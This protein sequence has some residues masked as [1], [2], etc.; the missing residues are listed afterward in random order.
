V[1]SPALLQPHPISIVASL[2]V[3]V[4]CVSIFPILLNCSNLMAAVSLLAPPRSVGHTS[5]ILEWLGLLDLRC[6]EVEAVSMEELS[7]D[8]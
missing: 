7:L 8:H 4:W 2:K 6:G 5:T 1:V 3:E